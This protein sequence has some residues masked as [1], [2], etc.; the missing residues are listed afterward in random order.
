MPFLEIANH[1]SSL[2]HKI[3]D[4]WIWGKLLNP[5]PV[6][7]PSQAFV[8][9]PPH[10][11]SRRRIPWLMLFLA[12]LPGGRHNRLR[13]LR[14]PVPHGLRSPAGTG[15]CSTRLLLAVPGKFPAA[16]AGAL[17]FTTTVHALPPSPLT[18][19]LPTCALLKDWFLTLHCTVGASPFLILAAIVDGHVHAVAVEPV[20]T[21]VALDHWLALI[22]IIWPLADTESFHLLTLAL[23]LPFHTFHALGLGKLLLPLPLLLLP[24]ALLF[25]CLHLLLPRQL[26]LL[27]FLLALAFLLGCLLPFQRLLCLLGLVGLLTLPLFPFLLLRS[28]SSFCF[29]SLL[30]KSQ[31][32]LLLPLKGFFL[33]LLLCC[34]LLGFVLWHFLLS[35]FCL[36]L[37]ALVL[38]LLLLELLLL[39]L[40]L[41]LSL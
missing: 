6:Q 34:Q 12:G 18:G 39:E 7:P 25:L 10:A 22:L 41:L 21:K 23:S 9:G 24:S 17:P 33:L 36:S 31:G 20:I 38:F 8:D 27:F 1:I 15:R 26:F 37:L 16:C 4:I 32:L 13:G 11:Y 29:L 35:C 3:C 5:S 2:W 30:L 19:S 14:A 28:R 40:L